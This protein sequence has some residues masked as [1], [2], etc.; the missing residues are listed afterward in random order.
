MVEDMIAQTGGTTGAE[1]A[2]SETAA[3]ATVSIQVQVAL[4][5]KLAS[6]VDGTET[7]FVFA[8]AVEGPPMP[9]AIQKRSA[10]E[11]PLLI[12]LDDTMHMLP[13]FRLSTFSA[14]TV[15]ARISRTGNAT[16][17]SGDLQGFVTPI[18]LADDAVVKLV[19]EQVVD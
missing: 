14:V 18:E 11:L 8:R 13:A 10:G 6:R 19:I 4:D 7:L 15:G 2:T 3:P 16:A 17:S 9:L 12:T 5:P 1:V